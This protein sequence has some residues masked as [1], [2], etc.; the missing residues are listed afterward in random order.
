MTRVAPSGGVRWP[1]F[2][3]RYRGILLFSGPKAWLPTDRA[4][5]LTEN[6]SPPAGTRPLSTKVRIKVN[7]SLY[8]RFASTASGLSKGSY[9]SRPPRFSKK[10]IG[11]ANC[12]LSLIC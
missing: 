1:R 12:A 11:E 7:N 2:R 4:G 10:G 6:R 8:W 3:H 5:S 9:L